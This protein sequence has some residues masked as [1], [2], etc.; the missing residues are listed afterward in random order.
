MFFEPLV[1]SEEAL[2]EET[3]EAQSKTIELPSMKLDIGNMSISEEMKKAAIRVLSQLDEL[4]IEAD[5]Q[6]QYL[7][8]LKDDFAMLQRQSGILTKDQSQENQK[9]ASQINYLPILFQ[10]SYDFHQG[11]CRHPSIA[12]LPFV[13]L[14]NLQL[15][16]VFF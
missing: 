3:E 6:Y 10:S 2:L 14:V 12:V 1:M 15:F 9:I 8:G 4:T 7:I 13:P 11:D 5:K 16:G